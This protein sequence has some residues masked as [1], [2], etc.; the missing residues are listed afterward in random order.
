[1]TAESPPFALQAGS[2]S[3]EQMRRAFGTLL[4]R[5]SSIGSVVGGIVGSKDMEITAG[6]GMNIEVAPG[7]A[8]IPGST[9]ATQSGYYARVSSKSTLAIAAADPTNPRIDRVA[10]VVTDAAYSGATNIYTPAVVTGTPTA[11]ANLTNL[12][13]VG[14]AP[15]SCLTLG[16]V[17][18][19]AKAPS[20]V[21]GDIKNVAGLFHPLLPNEAVTD[22]KVIKGRALM[23]TENSYSAQVARTYNEEYMP[24]ATRPTYVVLNMEYGASGDAYL[25]VYC[26]GTLICNINDNGTPNPSWYLAFSFICPAGQKWKAQFPA[27]GGAGT[28]KSSYLTL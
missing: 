9:S 10:A 27:S 22:A 11:G 6:A 13:G 15:A 8:W 24:S 18:V 1:M 23:E 28:L 5:G 20:I 17:E 7:E 25:I 3:A 2:Y 16:Y 12:N 19:P 14:A 21:S 4:E 26:D